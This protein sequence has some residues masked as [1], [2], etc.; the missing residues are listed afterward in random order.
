MEKIVTKINEGKYDKLLERKIRV[1][2]AHADNMLNIISNLN[3][4]N[5]II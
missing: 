4:L 1:I 2:R 3:E 5:Y